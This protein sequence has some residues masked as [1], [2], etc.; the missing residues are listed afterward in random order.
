LQI[1]L[2]SA[3]PGNAAAA[4]CVVTLHPEALSTEIAVTNN[5]PAPMAL[6]CGV[7]NHLRVSTPDATYALGL[8]GS[9]YRSVEPALSEFSIIPPDYRAAARQP[10]AAGSARHRWANRGFDMI[11]S[12]G[13]RDSGAADEQP[14]GE[15]DDDYKHMTDAMCR[16]YS[17]APRDFTI[18]DRVR[19]LESS[20]VH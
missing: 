1:E 19:D 13:G 8:Q 11:L 6:S 2:A 3:A 10:A 16:V 18:I 15:E 17:H 14:D 12:G 4:R 20:G 9:D 7:S 5:A